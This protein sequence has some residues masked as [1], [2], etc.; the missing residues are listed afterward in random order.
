MEKKGKKRL[1]TSNT[2]IVKAN[3][4][5]FTP[6]QRIFY[7]QVLSRM[8][9]WCYAGRGRI[10]VNGRWH[11]LETDQFL[12]LPWGAEILYAADA[13]K[14]FWVGGIHLIPDHPRARRIEKVVSHSPKAPEAAWRWRRDVDWPGLE[15]VQA[16]EARASDPL[17]LL[18][19]YL[20]ERFERLSDSDVSLR[21]LGGW[22]VEEVAEALSEHASGAGNEVVRRAQEFVEAHLDESITLADLARW[23][24]CSVSTMRRQFQQAL[25]VPPYEWILTTRM[26]RAQQLLATTTLRVKEIAGRVGFED[27][28]QFSRIFRQRIGRSPRE[29][30]DGQAFHPRRMTSG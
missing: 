23:S 14:P 4:F 17:R 24:D 15:G 29:F 3:W 22:L 16:G 18:A 26:R 19:T 25:G 30:R 8:L 20:V 13:E 9:L 2:A 7:P 12:F 5:Q 6:G 21:M 11:S 1:N 10:R 27:A 28:F